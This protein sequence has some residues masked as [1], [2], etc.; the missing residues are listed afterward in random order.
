MEKIMNITIKRERDSELLIERVRKDSGVNPDL[1]LQCRKCTSG[2]PAA[3]F[4]GTSPSEIIRM[5][6][7]G[8]KE[9]LLNME[10]I[11]LCASCGTCYERCPM[12]INMPDIIDSLR[13][14]AASEKAKAPSGNMP[15]MNRLLLAGV[16]KFGRTYDLGAMVLYRAGTLSFRDAGKFPMMLKKGKIALLPAKGS[17]TE[18][19]ERIFRNT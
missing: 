18:L 9:R 16:R 13:I 1:C 15:L 14:I 2:C 12:Q 6:Q 3:S 19:T 17:D 5:L 4:T 10:F 11:W 7:L 8:L